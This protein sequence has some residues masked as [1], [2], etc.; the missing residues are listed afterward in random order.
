MPC[1]S[2]QALFCNENHSEDATTNVNSQ[3]RAVS[4]QSAEPHPPMKSQR[5]RTHRHKKWR[6]LRLKREVSERGSGTTTGRRG[7]YEAIAWYQPWR[8]WRWTAAGRLLRLPSVPIPLRSPAALGRPVV[9]VAAWGTPAAPCQ[10]GPG[11]LAAVLPRRKGV[12]CWEALRQRGRS[13][14]RWSPCQNRHSERG[15]VGSRSQQ[16]WRRAP[17]RS[18]HQQWMARRNL[19]AGR[20]L[21]RGWPDRAWPRPVTWLGWKTLQMGWPLEKRNGNRLKQA[22]IQTVTELD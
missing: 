22:R 2:Q 12:P 5:R 21:Q 8:D 4:R 10:A 3:E 11:T 13:H 15:I 17:V 18:L 1:L 14:Q 16:R 19:Q 6:S 20:T 7:C 9:P